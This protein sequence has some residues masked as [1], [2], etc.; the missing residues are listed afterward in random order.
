MSFMERDFWD[1]LIAGLSLSDLEWL[2]IRI[3][4]RQASMHPEKIARK[5]IIRKQEEQ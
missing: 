5:T 1:L 4:R 3:K 2:E